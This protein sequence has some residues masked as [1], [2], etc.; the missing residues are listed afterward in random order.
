MRSKRIYQFFYFAGT[1]LGDVL[2]LKWADFHDCRLQYTMGKNCKP[3][4][5]KI[6]DKAIAIL[7]QYIDKKDDTDLV[8]PELRSVDL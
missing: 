7:Q 3:G 2:K 8:L 6:S 1:R 5:V 4:S